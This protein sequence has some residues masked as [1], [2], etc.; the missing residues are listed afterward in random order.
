MIKAILFDIDNTLIDF[1][2]MKEKSCEAA[3]EAMISK[4][5]KMKK[6]EA[7]K[8]IYNIYDK[9]GMEYRDVFEKIIK[10]GNGKIDYKIMASGVLAY[11]KAKENHLVTYPGVTSTLTKLKKK[12]K[13][14]IVSDAPS[15]KAWTRLISTDIDKFF[16]VIITRGDVKKQKNSFVPFNAAL[17]RLNIKPEE[18]I[19]VGDRIERDIHTAKKLGIHTCLA[20]YGIENPPARGKSGA[21]FEIDDVRELVGVVGNKLIKI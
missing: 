4:G 2:K 7:M 6:Q 17:K 13:L 20:R 11:R 9:R 5:L 16:D 8:E 19:M 3:V 21:D 1:M 15:M 10:K 14:A 18:A 12:Y